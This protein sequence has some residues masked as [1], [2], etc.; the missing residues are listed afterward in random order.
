MFLAKGF[1]MCFLMC[2]RFSKILFCCC[3]QTKRQTVVTLHPR[4]IAIAYHM[5]RYKHQF[6]GPL[7]DPVIH[8]T[9]K[10]LPESILEIHLSLCCITLFS[11]LWLK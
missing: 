10:L 2:S 3:L 5:L 8:L 9:V 1:V 11:A 4:Q 7:H 6:N